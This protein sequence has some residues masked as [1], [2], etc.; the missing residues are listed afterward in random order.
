MKGMKE[1]LIMLTI[2]LLLRNDPKRGWAFVDHQNKKFSDY[3]PF[4]PIV[5]GCE[6]CCERI[7]NFADYYLKPLTRLNSSFIQDTTDFV[8][9]IK[10]VK[11]NEGTILIS[12]DVSALYTN[13]PQEQGIEAV[14]EALFKRDNPKVP[15]EFIVRVL[16]IVLKSNIFEFNSELFI[17]LIGTAMG[18]RPAPSY[19]NLFMAKEIDPKIIELAKLI[20]S[21]SIGGGEGNRGKSSDFYF[22]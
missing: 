17:Q 20:E 13:I 19:A 11:S 12:A 22:C 5:S 7:S 6:S 1:I 21:E 9:K 8:K 15:T 10:D 2:M 14:R 3:P 18:S 4:R 16:E